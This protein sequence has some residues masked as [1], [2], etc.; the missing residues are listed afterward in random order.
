MAAL[1]QRI[2]FYQ[3]IFHKPEIRYSFR[4]LTLIL[5]V[6]MALLV[7]LTTLDYVRTE[8]QRRHVAQLQATQVRLEKAVVAMTEQLGRMVADPALEKQEVYLRESLQAK[9]Q[10]LAQLRGQSDSH[11]VHFS[12][13]LAGLSAL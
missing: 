12:D 13:V 6:V 8:M 7:A 1:E 4:Q 9:Y 5:L 11:Q 10:F 2:N 3:D